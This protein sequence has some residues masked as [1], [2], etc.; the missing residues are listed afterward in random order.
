MAQVTTLLTRA[1]YVTGPTHFKFVLTTIRV[2]DIQ[3]NSASV[4]LPVKA[5]HAILLVETG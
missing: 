2:N 3:D 5:N 4:S 1:G